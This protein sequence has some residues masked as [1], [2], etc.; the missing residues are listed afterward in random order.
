MKGAFM[1]K[2]KKILAP[3]DLSELSRAGLGYAMEIALSADAEV[4]VYNVV[5]CPE[6]APCKGFEY[7]YTIE[8]IPAVDEVVEKH[9][10]L[11]GEFLRTSFPETI[12]RVKLRQQ[13]SL[14]TPYR[15]IIEK[16]ASENADMIVMSTH[17]KTGLVH[18]LLGSVAERV[19]RLAACP[20]LIVRPK[21]E[22]I[23]RAAA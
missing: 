20:V 14:G 12:D 7:R 3:T 10:S 11:L 1:I 15:K 22:E 4:I 5:A 19:V 8:A 18:A 17:G 6:G 23:R 2:V 9:R 13:V 16:A 21:K